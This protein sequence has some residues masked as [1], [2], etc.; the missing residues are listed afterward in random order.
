MHGGISIGKFFVNEVDRIE[1]HHQSNLPKT[2]Y[3][4]EEIEA[5]FKG[6]A[7]AFGVSGTLFYLQS[8]PPY[9]TKKQLEDDLTVSE[10]YHWLRYLAWHGH[11]TNKY[12]KIMEKKNRPKGRKR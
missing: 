4:P 12:Q 3:T 2:A 10:V 11:T 7:S 9:Y 6:L 5:G 8:I 1:Q